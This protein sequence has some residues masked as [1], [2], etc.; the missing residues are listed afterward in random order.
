MKKVI[1]L[2]A[3]ALAFSAYGAQAAKMTRNAAVEQC[4]AQARQSAAPMTQVNNTDNRQAVMLY[5]ACMR[6]LGFRP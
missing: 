6:K 3:A 5:S 4:V 2:A 1:V